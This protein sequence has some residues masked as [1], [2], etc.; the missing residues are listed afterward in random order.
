[1][2][3]VKSHDKILIGRTDIIDLPEFGL[4]DMEAKI[5]TGA[6]TSAIHCSR[7]KL[8]KS[9]D[10]EYISFMIPGSTVAGVKGVKFKTADFKQR[11]IKSSNG[12]MECRYVIKTKV[13]MF[14]MKIKTEFSLTDRSDMKYPILLGRKLLRKRFLVDVSKANLSYHQKITKTSL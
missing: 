8:V 6:L 1:M 5:D 3:N 2:G 7:I 4:V 10:K 9:G 13:A 12:H 14:G 11:N